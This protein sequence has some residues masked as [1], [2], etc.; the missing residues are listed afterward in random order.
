MK[1]ENGLTP[2]MALAGAGLLTLASVSTA[3]AQAIT[4][5]TFDFSTDALVNN[6]G[7]GTA[8]NMLTFAA[9]LQDTSLKATFGVPVSDTT[10]QYGIVDNV[11]NGSFGTAPIANHLI[12][13]QDNVNS[14][15]VQS[16][17]KLVVTFSR[18]IYSLS[19]DWVAGAYLSDGST[20]DSGHFGVTL[21]GLAG[22][23]PI[24]A[25]QT[26]GLNIYEFSQGGFLY[27]PGGGSTFN[28]FTLSTP[29]EYG[30]AIGI[31]NLQVTSLSSV[32]EPGSLALLIGLPLSVFLSFKRKRK[33]RR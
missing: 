27:T 9:D 29:L 23:Q 7:N 25:D 26:S 14:T 28:G 21:Q 30:P 18:P 16:T 22:P 31:D 8:T 5:S 6:F 2:I 17:S 10:S 13:G 1:L 11:S 32:P 12:Y 24:F 4:S 19:F 20:F 3:H 33:S 15:T